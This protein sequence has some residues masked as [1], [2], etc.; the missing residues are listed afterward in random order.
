MSSGVRV[1]VLDEEMHLSEDLR[2]A[3]SGLVDFNHV[4]IGA[5]PDVNISAA[6]VVIIDADRIPTLSVTDIEQL[7]SRTIRPAKPL[8]FVGNAQS[9]RWLVAGKLLRFGNYI[10]RPLRAS[11]LLDMM[12]FLSSQARPADGQTTGLAQASWIVDE[13]AFAMTAGEQVLSGLFAFANGQSRLPKPDLIKAGDFLIGSLSESGL[14]S[15]VN[16]VRQHHD[17][18]YQHCLL[19]AGL[20]VGFGLKLKFRESDLQMLAKGALLHDLGKAHIP[21]GIL[22]KPGDLDQAELAVIREHPAIGERILLSEPDMEP[23]ILRVVRS[24]HEYLDGS[25]YPDGLLGNSIDDLVRLTTIADIVAALIE[26]R[27]YKAPLTGEAAFDVLDS[28]QGK[29]DMPIVRALKPLGR[30][31]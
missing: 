5:R 26:R 14:N 6:T 23:E 18:T 31:I 3:F 19:V 20:A 28:M 17:A 8:I 21:I 7:V 9:R 4:K 13:H 11:G 29:V 10:N 22:D 24:H 12:R 2:R 30:L 1:A 25:G 15:W 16:G 27:P